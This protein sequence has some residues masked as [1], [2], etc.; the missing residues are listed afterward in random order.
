VISDIAALTGRKSSGHWERALGL[1][2]EMR[3]WCLEPEAISYDATLSVREKSGQW[4]GTPVLLQET[5]ASSGA[6]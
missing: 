3:R 2:E 6:R 4:E 1:L 5:R